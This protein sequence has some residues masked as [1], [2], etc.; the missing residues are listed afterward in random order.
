MWVESSLIDA[1]L[2][3]ESSNSVL[4]E[5]I[6]IQSSISPHYN[7]LCFQNIPECSSTAF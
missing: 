5:F 2:N 6:R 3:L 1:E 7:K 4:K